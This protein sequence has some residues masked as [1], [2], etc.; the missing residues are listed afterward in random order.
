MKGKL[1]LRIEVSRLEKLH[2]I[3]AERKK[4]MTQLVEDW[5][6]RLSSNKIKDDSEA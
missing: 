3:A 6:D 1:N 2:L 4:T 5:I